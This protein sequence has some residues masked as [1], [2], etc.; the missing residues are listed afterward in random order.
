M[1]R[2]SQPSSPPQP[3]YASLEMLDVRKIHR[4]TMMMGTIDLSRGESRKM[5][6][7]PEKVSCLLQEAR[8][9]L[10][11]TILTICKVSYNMILG[12]NGLRMN[13]RVRHING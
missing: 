12:D 11:S 10:D 3:M 5:T 7:L 4:V 2:H 1:I 6:Q 8:I 13:K 9:F